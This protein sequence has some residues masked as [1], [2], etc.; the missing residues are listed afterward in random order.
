MIFWNKPEKVQLLGVLFE[1]WILSFIEV[2]HQYPLGFPAS[3]LFFHI[4]IGKQFTLT[5]RLHL[6]VVSDGITPD[7]WNV[8]GQYGTYKL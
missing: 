1:I 7:Y 3:R 5:P 8:Q 4:L 2:L 6:S